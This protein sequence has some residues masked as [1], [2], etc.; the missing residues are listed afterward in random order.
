M[1]VFLA[2]L[3]EVKIC[4]RCQLEKPLEEFISTKMTLM[5]YCTNCRKAYRQ[6]YQKRR[7]DVE[8]KNRRNS[9]LRHRERRI[10]DVNRWQQANK[11]KVA[12]SGKKARL[13][14][15]YGISVEQYEE[16]KRL[17]EN[18][19]PI[20][21]DPLLRPFVDHNHQTKQVRGLL[22]DRCNRGL[23]QFKENLDTLSRAIV[24]LLQNS[25]EE[26]SDEYCKS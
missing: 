20:C 3:A 21:Q 22:C 14:H 2:M 25:E 19:C 16:L 1:G 18:K 13:K 17:Q 15:H 9:Y 11:D 10:E 24:Y 26:T 6:E 5:S 8:K 4:P 23:G 7:P 12:K